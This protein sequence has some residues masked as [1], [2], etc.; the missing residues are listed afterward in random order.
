MQKFNIRG[1]AVGAGA[2]PDADGSSPYPEDEACFQYCIDVT[3]YDTKPTHS[4][5]LARLETIMTQRLA[6]LHRVHY[7]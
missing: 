2:A 4:L 7:L 1:G 6:L 3:M 5:D